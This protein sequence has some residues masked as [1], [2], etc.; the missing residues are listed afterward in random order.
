[1]HLAAKCLL[2]KDDE[3]DSDECKERRSKM[4]D[5]TSLDDLLKGNTNVVKAFNEENRTRNLDT[6]FKDKRWSKA[7]NMLEVIHKDYLKQWLSYV[8][9]RKCSK[10]SEK[11]T[12]NFST[13]LE[14]KVLCNICK[15]EKAVYLCKQDCGRCEECMQVEVVQ[16]HNEPK[17]D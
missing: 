6:E 1:M 8:P 16:H 12:Y 4:L 14:L 5:K 15:K 17:T 11:L 10:H 3:I 9:E 7:K 2:T 13:G